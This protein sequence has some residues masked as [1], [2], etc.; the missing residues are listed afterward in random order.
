MTKY[1]DFIPAAVALAMFGYA[2][3][4]SIEITRRN[5]IIIKEQSFRWG[6]NESTNYKQLDFCANAAREYASKDR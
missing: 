1:F 5:Q 2:I 3:A 4:T 6:C